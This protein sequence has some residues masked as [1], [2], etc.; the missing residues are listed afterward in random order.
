MGG[1]PRGVDACLHVAACKKKPDGPAGVADSEPAA[2][3]PPD[4]VFGLEIEFD[5]DLY[6]LPRGVPGGEDIA[7]S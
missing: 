3:E 6:S 1:C 2:R 7:V 5:F 4:E